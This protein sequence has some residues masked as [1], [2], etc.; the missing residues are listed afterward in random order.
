[1][2]IDKGFLDYE[3]KMDRLETRK[4]LLFSFDQI[5]WIL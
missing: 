4:L 2:D 5:E 1:M 3:R